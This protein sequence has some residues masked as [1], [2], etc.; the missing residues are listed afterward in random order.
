M[1]EVVKKRAPNRKYKDAL[2]EHIPSSNEIS[3]FKLVE[4][5]LPTHSTWNRNK[6]HIICPYSNY[7]PLLY[8]NSRFEVPSKFLYVRSDIRALYKKSIDELYKKNKIFASLAKQVIGCSGNES[9]K[10]NLEY[11]I[12]VLRSYL[13]YDAFMP[14]SSIRNSSDNYMIHSQD[15]M[16]LKE[17]F[18]SEGYTRHYTPTSVYTASRSRQ[19]TNAKAIIGSYTFCTHGGYDDGDNNLMLPF[20]MPVMHKEDL[21]YHRIRNLLGLPV[22]LKK[23]IVF[24]A[25]ELEQPGGDI[26]ITHKMFY[27]RYFLPLLRKTACTIFRVPM[28]YIQQNCFISNMEIEGKSIAEKAKWKNETVERFK[29]RL[30]STKIPQ[31]LELGGNLFEINGIQDVSSYTYVINTAGTETVHAEQFIATSGLLTL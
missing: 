9:G 4:L 27:Q 5:E 2:F 26:S 19:R 16:S 29:S 6:L 23:I 12:K 24:V 31:E 15:S 10:Y 17:A 3:E 7:I 28:S 30:K 22:D 11:V 25:S 21:L 8:L 13:Y 14:W 20:I 18:I 1:T